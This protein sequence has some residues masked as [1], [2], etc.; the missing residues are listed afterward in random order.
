[1]TEKQIIDQFFNLYISKG[2]GQKTSWCGVPIQKSPFDAWVLQEIIA[3]KKPDV[4]IECGSA[5]G[6]SALFMAMVMDRIEK[7][8]ILS[9]ELRQEMSV[10]NNDHPR[11]TYFTGSTTDEKIL[12]DIK[13]YISPTDAVMVILDSNHH[14]EHVYKELQ[15]YSDLVSKGNYLIIEDTFWQSDEDLKG[16][17]DARDRFLSEND[18]FIIDKEREHFLMTYNTGGYLLKI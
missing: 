7:G 9:I 15:M 16:P 2:L 11:I 6:G 1:M 10:P 12:S 3:D 8:K 17:G 4:I 13:S 5:S 18:S 14:Y